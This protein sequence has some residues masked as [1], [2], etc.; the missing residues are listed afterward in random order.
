MSEVM[1]LC[2]SCEEWSWTEKHQNVCSKCEGPIYKFTELEPAAQFG[3]IADWKPYLSENMGH[4]PV[5]IDG[6]AK[7]REELKKR[8]LK[9]EWE[10]ANV[11]QVH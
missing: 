2:E 11:N 10:D 1:R 8:D 4:E 9:N 6:K 7:W 5:W 3:V